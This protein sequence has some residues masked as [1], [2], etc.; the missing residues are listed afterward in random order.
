MAPSLIARYVEG[1]DVEV[2]CGWGMTETTAVA[3][4]SGLLP[5]QADLSAAEQH[6]LRSRPG[7]SLFGAEVKIVDASG[8]TLPRDGVSIGELHVRGLWVLSSYFKNEASPLRDGWFPTGDVAKIDP[9]GMV[10]ITDRVKDVIKSGGEW[11]SSIDLEHAAMEHPSVALASV[12][13]V[14]HPKW[15][16]RP[17]MFVV[18]KPGQPLDRDEL[19]GFLSPRVARWWLPD[20]V[21]FLDELPLNGTGKVDKLS[22]RRRYAGISA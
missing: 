11:I 7:R 22:L 4:M 2:R 18:R 21:V 14:S 20:D 8:Q 9:D 10:Q 13:G 17:M 5:S 6:T 3:T 12:I 16:E 1:F 15:D 19:I